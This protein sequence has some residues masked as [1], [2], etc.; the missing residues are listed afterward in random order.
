M[1]NKE[2][3]ESIIKDL[4][5]KLQEAEK[6]TCEDHAMKYAYKYGVLQ[7]AIKSVILQLDRIKQ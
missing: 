4:E 7:G 3:A 5:R 6:Y 1:K 2:I